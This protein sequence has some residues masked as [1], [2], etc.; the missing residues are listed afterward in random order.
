MRRDE[1]RHVLAA[2]C[3]VHDVVVVHDEDVVRG[4][5]RVR[6]TAL[7][8]A[9]GAAAVRRRLPRRPV[10]AVV[11]GPERSPVPNRGDDGPCLLGA[12]RTRVGLQLQ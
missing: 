9:G 3:G 8:D 12:C 11:P 6:P 7:A 4:A 5:H 2:D 10:R 1:P